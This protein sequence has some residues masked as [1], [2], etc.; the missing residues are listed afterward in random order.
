MPSFN[1]IDNLRACCALTGLLWTQPA[2]KPNFD[3]SW[4]PLNPEVNPANRLQSRDFGNFLNWRAAVGN[5]PKL[6]SPNSASAP[7]GHLR[8]KP[9]STAIYL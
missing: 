5:L 2:A 4:I 6:R 1:E 3:F 7:N 9:N 8:G